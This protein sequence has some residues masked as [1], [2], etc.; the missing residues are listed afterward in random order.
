MTIETTKPE[1]M[2]G[3]VMPL[4]VGVFVTLVNRILEGQAAANKALEAKEDR[5]RQ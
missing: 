1:A 3:L 4:P 2:D 5:G